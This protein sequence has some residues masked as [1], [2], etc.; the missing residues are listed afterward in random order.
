MTV[1]RRPRRAGDDYADV[2]AALRAL[3]SVPPGDG[4][5]RRRDAVITRC[6]PL[7]EHIARRFHGRGEPFDDL[8]QVARLGLVNAIDRFDADKGDNF[9]AFAVPTIMGEVRRHFRDVGW[10]MHVPRRAKELHLAISTAS[11]RLAQSLGRSPSAAEVADELGLS[12]HEVTEGLIARSAYQPDSMDA[13]PSAGSEGLSLGDV[14]GGEDPDLEN[15]E[16]YVAVKPHLDALPERERRILILRFFGEM[17][18]S[19]IAERVGLSQM[20]VSRILARTLAELRDQLGRP[21]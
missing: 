8:L 9:V 4:Y 17:T 5:D 2:P 19:Q 15:V 7:A 18:Q 16:G 1:H 20:H 13:P 12:I 21:V 11:E 14:V 6:L 10:A 3:H